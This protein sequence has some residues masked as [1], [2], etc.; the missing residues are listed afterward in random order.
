MSMRVFPWIR[1]HFS[2]AFST[3]SRGAECRRAPAVVRR[4]PTLCFSSFG[5]V[6]SL[7]DEFFG[8]I[9]RVETLVP[10]SEDYKCDLIYLRA[11]KSRKKIEG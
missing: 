8:G 2:L 9:V 6:F 10:G 11:R 3:Q 5:R 1:A 4:A 7:V